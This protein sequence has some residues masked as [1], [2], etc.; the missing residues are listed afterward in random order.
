[1]DA[2][3]WENEGT[4]TTFEAVCTLSLPPSPQ[5][6]SSPVLSGGH[7]QTIP[8]L[9]VRCARVH[10]LHCCFLCFQY[11]KIP[12]PTSCVCC[13]LIAAGTM[14][15]IVGEGEWRGEGRGWGYGKS[16]FWGEAPVEGA[17]GGTHVLP[18]LWWGGSPSQH[19]QSQDAAPAA[20]TLQGPLQH[21]AHTH[22]WGHQESLL[23]EPVSLGEVSGGWGQWW[24]RRAG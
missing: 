15:W 11:G 18:I 19:T 16:V 9:L 4:C 3:K 24:P 21:T 5:P 6:S 23:Q 14:H 2:P 7:K 8:L 22:H 20:A 10:L 13:T 12:A 1:M 17:P